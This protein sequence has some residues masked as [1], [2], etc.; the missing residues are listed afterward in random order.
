QFSDFAIW[1]RQF[2]QEEASEQLAYWKQKLANLPV[3]QLPTDHPRPPEPGYRGARRFVSISQSIVRGL[4]ALAREERTTLYS[5]L[6]T[7]FQI[8]LHR[9]SGQDEIVVGTPVAG[10]TGENTESLIGCFIN[11]LVMRGD[12]SGNPTF[13]EALGRVSKM[14][15]EA[16][17]NQNVALEKLVDELRVLRDLSRNPLYQVTFQLFHAPGQLGPGSKPVILQK[18][19]TQMDLTFDLFQSQAGLSGTI[20]FSTELFEPATIERMCGHFQVL[21]E[22]IV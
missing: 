17:G 7:A 1:E 8:L 11:A 13:R 16:L 20:E 21:L 15:I 3:L 10:R 5:T 18:G 4:D 6:L 22:G 12:F 19:T 9:Y 2:L 14:G